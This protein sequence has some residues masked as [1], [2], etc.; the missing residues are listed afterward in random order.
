MRKGCGK[1]KVK[2]PL[3]FKASIS[4][5]PLQQL[6]NLGKNQIIILAIFTEIVVIT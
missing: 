3:D 4:I 1:E 6:V 2:F 5:S